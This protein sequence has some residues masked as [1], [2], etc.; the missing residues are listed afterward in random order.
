MSS[1]DIM[2]N[3][4]RANFDASIGAVRF[5]DGAI[6]RCGNTVCGP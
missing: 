3:I 1:C 5:V 6:W 2:L 4:Q